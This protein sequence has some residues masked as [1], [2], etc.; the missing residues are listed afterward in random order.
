MCIYIYPLCIIII[1]IVPYLPS[2]QSLERFTNSHLCKSACVNCIKPDVPA[3][4]QKT[5]A[6]KNTISF[7]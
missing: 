3:C 2:C 5:A 4:I 7:L 6:D 1:V